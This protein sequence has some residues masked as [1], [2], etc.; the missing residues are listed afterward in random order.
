VDVIF[1]IYQKLFDF[2][3]LSHFCVVWLWLSVCLSVCLS[4]TVS[5]S[6]GFNQK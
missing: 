5:V 1:W 2:V 6:I 4:L 3:F